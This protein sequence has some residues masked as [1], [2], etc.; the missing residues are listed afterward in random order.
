MWTYTS[1]ILWK[2]FEK[3][4]AKSDELKLS[5]LSDFIFNTL[6]RKEGVIFHEGVEDL[7]LDLK[8]L[9]KIGVLEIYESESLDET[10]IKVKDQ[11]KLREAA[12]VAESLPDVMKLDALREYV[13]RINKAIEY[14]VV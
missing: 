8:Y 6:W 4:A 10:K 7:Y 3:I 14:A 13:E 11:E 5:E 1:Y 12:K 2:Y 9:Q